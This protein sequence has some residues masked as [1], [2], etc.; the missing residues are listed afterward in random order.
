MAAP[1]AWRASSY[2]CACLGNAAPE[3]PKT[4]KHPCT[5]E[6]ALPGA[7]PILMTGP[8][9]ECVPNFSE[10]RDRR[11]MDA[12]AGSIASVAGVSV[13]DLTL[14]PDHNRSVIT[15]AGPPDA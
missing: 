9:V 8:L 4:V 1:L 11:K 15:F 7:N 14:D 3:F 12:I 10:G 5:M 13:L 6:D 2:C